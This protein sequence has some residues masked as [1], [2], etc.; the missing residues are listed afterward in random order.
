MLNSYVKSHGF[1]NAF[2][3]FPRTGSR[4]DQDRNTNLPKSKKK[5]PEE[6][7]YKEYLKSTKT[8][9]VNDKANSRLR[10][11]AFLTHIAESGELTPKDISE[12]D[13]LVQRVA[14]ILKKPEFNQ[15]KEI[16]KKGYRVLQKYSICY[17]A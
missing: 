12:L 10:K 4:K 5:P 14:F 1:D 11:I 15:E 3:Q 2:E 8:K 9:T 16:I 6:K 13:L 17:S 7:L